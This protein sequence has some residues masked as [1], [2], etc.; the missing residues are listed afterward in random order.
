MMDTELKKTNKLDRHLLFVI[1]STVLMAG[2]LLAKN[3]KGAEYRTIE[4]FLYGRFEARYRPPAGTGALASFFTYH[5]FSSSSAE[6]NEIDF[7]I[8]GRYNH[9]VQTTSIGPYQKIRASHQWVPFNTHDDF[10]TYAFEWTPDYIAWFV[11]NQEVYRQDGDFISD[12]KFP[13]KI[14]MNIWNPE[15][16]DWAGPW[17]D[18]NLPLFAYYD[19][20]S[21]AS[22]TPGKGNCGSNN[23]FTLQWKDDFDYWDHTRWEKATHTFQGNKCDFVPENILF[24]NGKLILCLTDP[25]H[26][27]GQDTQPPTM[28]YVW[29]L[30][31][32]VYIRFNE[33]LDTLSA[34]NKSNY[35][36]PGIQINKAELL[37]AQT[38]KLS[39]SGLQ[40]GQRYNLVCINV[41]DLAEPPNKQIGQVKS[42][43]PLQYL[44]FPIQINVGGDSVA[45]YR[46]DQLWTPD[47]LYGHQDG[48]SHTWFGH[49]EIENT[50]A[51]ELFWT[52]L[53]G[54]VN[55]QIRVPVGDYQINFWICE[56]QFQQ[57]GA[58][59]FDII[60]NGKKIISSLDPFKQFGY[61]FAGKIV[62][63]TVTAKDGLL[64]MHFTA[65]AGKTL[66][67]AIQVVPLTTRIGKQSYRE[68]MKDYSLVKIFP[69]PFNSSTTFLFKSVLE[70]RAKIEIY[71]L[72]GQKV[73]SKKLANLKHGTHQVRWFP[74][75][76]SSGIYFAKIHLNKDECVTKKLVLIK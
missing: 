57:Q 28:L 41:Q 65:I 35:T 1:M 37:D 68:V 45:T 11:D 49:P 62:A 24:K 33:A 39:T 25:E 15:Y 69:N 47:R 31:N 18:E 4:S 55:Y 27:G 10:H 70:S 73:W 46:S 64:S 14:M 36:I 42:F 74:Q 26:I 3:Y 23:N 30:E 16:E 63:D 71:N 38:V 58:R 40:L 32:E 50:H 48:I 44:S 21:Y 60:V 34:Q 72:K 8:L 12:F 5:D 19:Y 51:D 61:R 22:Y 53:E 76:H 2:T 6:W 29:A 75:Q 17:F 20:V 9:V 67:N 7:E 52:E 13:Q 43:T 54:V 66:L 56:N 59:V